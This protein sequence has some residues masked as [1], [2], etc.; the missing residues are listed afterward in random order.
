MPNWLEKKLVMR[1][2]PIPKIC[3][4]AIGVGIDVSKDGKHASPY[5]ASVADRCA[6]LYL[7]GAVRNVL[8]TGGYPVGA[9]HKEATT[10]RDHIQGRVP[11]DKLVL[12]LNAYRTYMNADNTLAIMKDQGWKSAIVVAQQWHARRVLATFH[13]RWQGS[14][15]QIYVTKAWSEYGGGSQSRLDSFWTFAAWDTLAFVI[16]KVKGYV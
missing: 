10:M 9:D 15:C 8:F 11:S 13:R 7:E 5:S 12:E 16:S 4:V 2:D 14:G 3:D 1:S 6:D